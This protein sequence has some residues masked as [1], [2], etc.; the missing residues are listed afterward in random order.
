M[1][2]IVS[3]CFIVFALLIQIKAQ[4]PSDYYSSLEGKYTEE[5]KTATHLAIKVHLRLSYTAL[6]K[7]FQQTDCMPDDTSRICDMYSS[8]ITYFSDYS[9]LNKEHCVPNSW[10]GGPTADNEYAYRDLNNLYPANETVNMSKSNNPLSEVG[11]TTLN[12]GVSKSGT[13]IFKGFSGKAFEPADEYK[14]DFARTYLYMATCYQDYTTWMK[15][16][17]GQYQIIIG[18]YPSIQPWAINLL[19]KWHR[20]DPLSLKETTRNNI[21]FVL[22]ENR[23]PFIDYPQLAEYIWGNMKDSIWHAATINIKDNTITQPTIYPNPSKDQ[24][25]INIENS[26]SSDFQYDIYTIT[27]IMKLSGHSSIIDISQLPTGVYSCKITNQS[28]VY[29]NKLIIR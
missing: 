6:W 5:L 2:K 12:N 4:P 8:N 22:Q 16:T 14:G 7:Y 11:A 13:S 25:H 3:F 19:L 17:T 15:D 28:K 18:A 21:V 27:G 26:S 9:T 10:W 1:K 24:I 20:Q 23:N 29:I